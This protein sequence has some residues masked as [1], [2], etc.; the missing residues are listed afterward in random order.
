M[1]TQI[2]MVYSYAGMK[3]IQEMKNFSTKPYTCAIL[4]TSV[5]E[6][7]KEFFG[8]Y[9][10]IKTANPLD[11]EY[12]RTTIKHA[13]EPLDAAKF[14][15]LYWATYYSIK[16]K[17]SKNFRTSSHDPVTPKGIIKRFAAAPL[18]DY[19]TLSDEQKGS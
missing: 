11:F 15:D 14:P 8:K 17:V 9:N 3:L 12:A 13:I 7:A 10:D 18:M 2:S 6:Q 5:M 16:K 4:L 1:Y 19:G